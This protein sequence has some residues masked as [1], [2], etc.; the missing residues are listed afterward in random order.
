[1]D[2]NIHISQFENFKLVLMCSS[3]LTPV[4]TTVGC[5]AGRA[6][7]GLTWPLGTIHVHPPPPLGAVLGPHGLNPANKR[8]WFTVVECDLRSAKVRVMGESRQVRG[9]GKVC[10]RGSVSPEV[11]QGHGPSVTLQGPW[12]GFSAEAEGGLKWC[13]QVDRL[14]G[15]MKWNKLTKCQIK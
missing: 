3:S 7:R 15:W 1:M 2:V 13:V 5:P 8:L 9:V 10:V 6:V 4:S 12:K 14:H 11:W